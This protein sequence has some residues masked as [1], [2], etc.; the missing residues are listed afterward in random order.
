[1]MRMKIKTRKLRL[2]KLGICYCY[3]PCVTITWLL[4]DL[5]GTLVLVLDFEM[6]SFDF[7]MEPSMWF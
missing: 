5:R 3:P 4:I 7:Y 2:V 1:M 6:T